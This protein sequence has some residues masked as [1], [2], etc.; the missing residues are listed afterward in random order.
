[1]CHGRVST[2]WWKNWH[3]L[4]S[5]ILGHSGESGSCSQEQFELSFVSSCEE[6]SVLRI[7]ME[8]APDST[9]YGLEVGKLG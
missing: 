1:M 3:H 9:S 5:E 2:I 7:E 4:A 8:L 6:L